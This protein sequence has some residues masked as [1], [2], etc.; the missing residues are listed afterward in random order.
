GGLWSSL[1][2]SPQEI[3]IQALTMDPTNSSILYL[4][5]EGLGPFKTTDGGANWTQKIAGL[6]DP[7]APY[8][9]SF[10]N[11]ADE[12]IAVDPQN[13][14][15]VYLGTLDGA[16]FKSTDGADSWV[17]MTTLPNLRVHVVVDPADSSVVY[18]GT[19]GGGVFRSP[20][21][22]VTWAAFNAGLDSLVNLTLAF[23][24]SGR[25]FAGTTHSV[26]RL[27]P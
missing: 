25:L 3:D 5:T 10:R 17:K 12:S 21:G 11:L 23:A 19:T 6:I 22:G 20:D 13:P 1:T 8:I 7:A 4:V 16:V 27:D 9:E 14:S 15:T 2:T 26:F 18:A 24:P